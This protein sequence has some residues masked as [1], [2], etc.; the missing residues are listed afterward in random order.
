MVLYMA[1]LVMEV[2]LAIHI[3]LYLLVCVQS[4]IY[5][6]KLLCVVCDFGTSYYEEW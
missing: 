5:L 6:G 4:Y 3:L 1:Y 2:L